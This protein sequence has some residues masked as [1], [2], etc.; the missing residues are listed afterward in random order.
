MPTSSEV[1][2]LLVE[3]DERLSDEYSQSD[4]H[5]RTQIDICARLIEGII[6]EI[7]KA[8]LHSRTGQIKKLSKELTSGTNEL[9]SL[10]ATIKEITRLGQL[11][12]QAIN[13]LAALLPVL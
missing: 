7:V 12:Q 2:S 1:L 9:A 13:A 8:D 3:A 6:R 5:V 10:K 4:E 11:G